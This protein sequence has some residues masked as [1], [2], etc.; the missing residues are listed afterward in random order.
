MV[1]VHKTM[2]VPSEHVESAKYACSLLA[3]AGGSGMFST[4][5]SKDGLPPPSHFVSSGLIEDFFGD[6]LENPENLRSI[7][8][9]YNLDADT[10]ISIISSAEITSETAEEVFVRMGLKLASQ[11][12]S[13]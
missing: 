8:D 10:L 12:T 7:A 11:E 13:E 2:V 5:L 3:G 4:G 1:W 9:K 6:L